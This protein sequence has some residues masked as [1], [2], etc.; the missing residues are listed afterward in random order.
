MQA[1]FNLLTKPLG[2]LLEEA[3]LINE[4]HLQVA[5][6]EKDIYPHLKFGE[7]L[8]LHGWLKQET[9]DFFADKMRQLIKEETFDLPIGNFFK[10]AGLLSEKDI[11]D[12]LSEQKKTGVKFGSIAVLKGCIK[13]QTLDF[14]LKYFT[15]ETNKKTD[16]QYKDK[17]TLTQK[18]LSLQNQNNQANVTKVAVKR[19]TLSK[20]L[21]TYCERAITYFL[22]A[23]SQSTKLEKRENLNGF[24]NCYRK[25]EE[26]Q[27]Q[28][29]S[30]MGKLPKK[31]QEQLDQI[32]L[33][34]L[35]ELHSISSGL[36]HKTTD[37]LEPLSKIY[38]SPKERFRSKISSN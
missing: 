26:H 36:C 3:G 31:S 27:K 18:R 7:I 1:V 9:A 37:Y 16:F 6:M 12:I 14:F 20:Y 38:S 23:R 34:V 17:D 28:N 10:Q 19:H 8:V 2:E 15:L 35:A 11:Q 5:L 21:S 29:V 32:Y 33:F 30:S 22:K 13:K 4:G 25:I 24:L